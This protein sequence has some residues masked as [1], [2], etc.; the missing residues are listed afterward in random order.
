MG[1]FQFEYQLIILFFIHQN[2]THKYT[3]NYSNNFK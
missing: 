1:M 2:I 3:D